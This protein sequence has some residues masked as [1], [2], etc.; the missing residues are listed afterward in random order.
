MASYSWG[1]EPAEKHHSFVCTW[2]FLFSKLC[3]GLF[4]L[5]CFVFESITESTGF[6]MVFGNKTI[7]PFGLPLCPAET[8]VVGFWKYLNAPCL[9]SHI[10]AFYQ[11]NAEK[12]VPYIISGDF[13]V[14]CIPYYSRT[15]KFVMISVRWY[16][17][18][19]FNKWLLY[20]QLSCYSLQKKK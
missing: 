4:P 1:E 5:S 3:N 9:R 8:E 20:L 7:V 15:S 10:I 14:R 19:T 11:K 2:R 13:L 6:L 16:S 12:M 17:N 18:K